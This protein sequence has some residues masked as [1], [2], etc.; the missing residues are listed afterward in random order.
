MKSQ[1]LKVDHDKALFSETACLIQAPKI[2]FKSAQ[3]GLLYNAI[4]FD[5]TTLAKN[6]DQ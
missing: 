1:Y 3:V 2:L 5:Y 4:V 6:S